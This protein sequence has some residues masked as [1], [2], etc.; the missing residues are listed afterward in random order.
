MRWE[1]L[2]A[3]LE[4]QLAAAERAEDEAQLEELAR[5]EAA[6]LALLDRLAPAVGR[7]VRVRVLGGGVV[8][9]QLRDYAATWLLLAEGGDELLA[10]LDAVGSI[11]GLGREATPPGSAGPL[12]RRLGLAHVLRG[13][14]RDRSRVLATLRDGTVLTGT[15]DRVGADFVELAEH[16]LD[17]WR[18]PDQVSAVLVVPFAALAVL[19][20]R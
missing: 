14:A 5:A 20:R 7:S 2:F 4:S 10:P 13:I 18:R 15:L 11:S 9:G 12:R 3:D 16:P 17:E 6:R 19:R 1:E 8:A